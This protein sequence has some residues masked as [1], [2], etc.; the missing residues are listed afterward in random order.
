[1]CNIQRND[2]SSPGQSW[3]HRFSQLSSETAP[4]EWFNNKPQL[5]ELNPRMMVF[6]LAPGE[7][8]SKAGFYGRM[9]LDELQA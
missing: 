4:K 8:V 9:F 1:V 3:Q 2:E 6:L 7:D 5:I